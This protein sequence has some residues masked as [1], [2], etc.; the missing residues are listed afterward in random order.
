M[1][2][3]KIKPEHKQI[4]C[5]HKFVVKNLIKIRIIQDIKYLQ[6]ILFIGTTFLSIKYLN[7][8]LHIRMCIGNFISKEKL[9]L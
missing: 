4:V 1:N 2:F 5:V 6:N 9:L 7:C 8:D 3:N